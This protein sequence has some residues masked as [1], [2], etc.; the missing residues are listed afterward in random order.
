MLNQDLETVENVKDFQS[1]YRQ[2]AK[3]LLGQLITESKHQT[4]RAS[5]QKK[6]F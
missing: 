1:A 4:A 3:N 5:P 6:N 2:L